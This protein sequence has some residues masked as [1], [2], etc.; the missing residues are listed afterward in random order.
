MPWRRRKSSGCSTRVRYTLTPATVHFAVAGIVTCGRQSSRG[1]SPNSI[2]EQWWLS[3][4]CEPHAFTAA[5]HRACGV[6]PAW[7][8]AYTPR[9][10]RCSRPRR[11]HERTASSLSPHA[12]SSPSDSTPIASAAAAA[13]SVSTFRSRGPPEFHTAP[14][15][16]TARHTGPRGC[17]ESA[18]KAL[19]RALAHGPPPV[20]LTRPA[21][22][23]HASPP[24][25]PRPPRRPAC[26]LS[27]PGERQSSTPPGHAGA[28]LAIPAESG[29]SADELGLLGRAPVRRAAADGRA[30]E[31]GAAAGASPAALAVGDQRARVRAAE[32]H[33]RADGRA[34]RAAEPVELLRREGAGRALG[35]QAGLP[36][37]L[38]G[39]EVADAGDY[40][41]DP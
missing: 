17:H 4:A 23:S 24:C 19:R 14:A 5:S 16:R 29:G 21:C 9:W 25:P 1:S 13:T 33:R 22:G 38:V 3:A 37:R 15:C 35:R 41:P 8:T 27:V 20:H 6:R 39:E 18:A 36:E 12:R 32:P 40:A 31:L 10:M 7:P 2:S 28:R 11:S 34:D 26:R 30:G